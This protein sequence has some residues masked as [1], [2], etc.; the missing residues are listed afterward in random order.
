MVLLLHS[1]YAFRAIYFIKHSGYFNLF[2]VPVLR[3]LLPFL[4]VCVVFCN[5][6][7]GFLGVSYHKSIFLVFME[8]FY[9]LFLSGKWN[10]VQHQNILCG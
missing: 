4:Q 3:I 10:G 2:L 8:L 6:L 7:L 9:F 1:P 5:S